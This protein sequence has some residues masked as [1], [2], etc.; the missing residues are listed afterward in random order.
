MNK[1]ML[2]L[3]YILCGLFHSILLGKEIT[4]KEKR[5]HSEDSM[6]RENGSPG[7]SVLNINNMAYWVG[8][9]GGYTTSGSPN[10]TMADYPIFTGGFIYADGMLWGAKVKG[11]GLGDEVRVGGS[12]YNHG[13]KAGR[14]L[15]DASGNVLGSDDPANNH[16]WRVRTDWANA[17]LSFDAANFYA[18]SVADVTPA[19]IA[20]VKGQYE[21]DWMNWPAAWGAPYEDVDEN[22]SYNPNIDIPGYPG[23]DQTIWTVANDI[24]KIVNASGD[25]IEY[26]S[27]A[28]NLYGSD[29]IGIELQLTIWGY[30]FNATDPMGNSIFK[31]ATIKYTGLPGGPSDAIMDSVYIAQW[32]DPDLGTFTD[33]YVGCDIDLSFGYVYNGNRLDGVFD[34]IF[35]LPVPAGGYDFLQGPPDN[36]DIDGDGNEEEFLGMTSF[37]YFGAG[38]SISDPD[39]SS[40]SGSL[41]FYNLMEGFLPRPEYPTQIPWT[42]PTNGLDTKFVLS[43]DPTSGSGWIDGIQLPPGDRRMVM[44]SGPFMMELGQSVDIVIGIIGGIG[45]DNISSLSAAKFNNVYSQYAYDQNFV[46]PSAPAIPIVSVTSMTN[47]IIL[48]WDSS[49]ED[50]E[51]PEPLGF[52]FEGYNV[53]QL[54]NQYSSK[55]EAL[56]LQTFDKINLIQTILNPSYNLE[57]GLVLNTPVEFGSDT[58]I[59]RHFNVDWDYL[60]DQP[61]VYGQTYYFAV[62]AYNFLPDNEGSPFKS[63][64]S[65]FVP[66]A[67]TFG[68]SQMDY[69]AN[70]GELIP[71]ENQGTSNASIYVQV[72]SP[73]QLTGDSYQVYFDEQGYYLDIDGIWKPLFGNSRGTST[74]SES[75][76]C[77]GSTITATAY[78]SSIVGTID[79]VLDFTLTCADGAWIDGMEFGFPS[80]FAS[81]VNTWGITG[82]GN[83]CSYGSGSGQNCVDLDGIW[84]GDVLLFGSDIQSGF[85]AFESSNE[86]TVNFTP[87]NFDTWDLPL[88]VNY[89]I[90]DDHY[91][92]VN[93]DGTGTATASSQNFQEKTEIHWNLLNLTT[94]EVRLEDQTFINGADLYD[95]GSIGNS[96][97]LQYNRNAAPLIDGFQVNVEGSYDSPTDFF[98]YDIARDAANADLYGESIWDMTS[99][100]QQGWGLTAK[101]TDTYGSG[102]TSVDFLQ[103]DIEVRW[104]GEFVDEPTTTASGVVYYGAD[105]NL[106]HSYVWLDGSRIGALTDHPDAG[107]PGDGSP[108]RVAVPF[109]VWDIEHPDGP[110]QIDMFIYDRLQGYAA[111]D[112]V[113]VFNPFD[114]MY[115][116]FLQHAYQEDGQ[117]VDGPTGVPADWLTWN[118]VWWDAQFNQGDVVRFNYANPIQ[119]GVDVFSF[120]TIAPIQFDIQK[121][122]VNVDG[123]L[124]IADVVSFINYLLSLTGLDS[125]AQLYAA[126]FNYDLALNI[127]DAVGIINSILN[128]QMRS[129]SISSEP[130]I[131]SVSLPEEPIV[132]DNSLSLPIEIITDES[133]AA[134][135]IEMEYEYEILS[136]LPPITVG[137]KWND[138]DVIYHTI[139]PGKTVYLFYSLSGQEIPTDAQ[140]SL[141]FRN[142]SGHSEYSTQVKLIETV[143]ADRSGKSTPIKYGNM[144]SKTNIIPE[145]YAMHPNY[146]NPFNPLTNIRYDI[147]KSSN[148]RIDIFNILGHKIKSLVNT[149]KMA[150]NHNVQWS[151][152]NEQ[153]KNLPSGLYIVRFN[154]GGISSQQKIMLL[155]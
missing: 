40:Y 127:S 143:F 33:D 60:N 32:I 133:L 90:Y 84:N 149:T 25:S 94:G 49:T 118:V 39:L 78:A 31:K 151:G 117:Y 130:N 154:A 67:V 86:F 138:I 35:D 15:T 1:N 135:Q 155:K 107:N 115:T 92:D 88:Y 21:Y 64:E 5:Y 20:V 104:V 47:E 124:N 56:R 6:T 54:P 16:V 89:V 2:I 139:E 81:K 3:I 85:G 50:V 29:P 59:Q 113:Y 74:T 153:N 121:G 57:F 58:G 53:Y 95:G 102:L 148:V 30:A 112:T 126:D 123:E 68:S 93:S 12:T 14:I 144:V 8:K 128:G 19:Q 125:D 119:P 114:R 120:T 37:T 142:I 87:D 150:G 23:A 108:F 18:T 76:D 51:I 27:T 41:Q 105:T 44:S 145:R 62:T 83:F 116:H 122:D 103:R 71:S 10:G 13:M 79:L 98:G 97:G 75:N 46:L 45:N 109:E 17:D 34:G 110:Q 61:L 63:L 106:P 82:D 9:D 65:S 42:D 134:F 96:M 52:E 69:G 131:V 26:I 70:A 136:P 147:P 137:E 7:I 11:D 28:P 141:P 77:S 55:N 91:T 22:G 140:L 80:G 99:Y 101:A 36:M 111:G 132:V 72:I 66:I 146:P 129:N 48:D 38:S 152:K 73:E 4:K 100:M 24:P 43:G